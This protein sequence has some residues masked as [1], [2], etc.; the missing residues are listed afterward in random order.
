MSKIVLD[1]N[2]LVYAKDRSSKF[3]L[4]ALDFIEHH[5]E[6]FT[7]S[8]NLVE[9]FSVVTRG[10]KPALAP[11]EAGNDLEEFIR[12]A[13]VLYPS[14]LSSE[15][16]HRLVRKYNPKGLKI[17]DFDIVSIALSAGINKIATF[18]S[19]DFSR[20]EEIEVLVPN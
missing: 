11:H 5:D 7:T 2:I 9:Y 18:N 16:L 20:I 4:E 3:H 12:L 6:L 10:D 14:V 17:H 15:I 13:V 8:K 19:S 1:T